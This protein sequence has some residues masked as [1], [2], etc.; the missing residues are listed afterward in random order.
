MNNRT[1]LLSL[2][3]NFIAPV[4]P[5]FAGVRNMAVKLITWSAALIA[6]SQ[7]GQIQVNPQFIHYLTEAVKI[8]A[9]VGITA[10]ATTDPSATN[11][12]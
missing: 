3:K 6:L 1:T 5:S 7:T 8:A 2:Y 4:H 10:Q 11:P 9:A 12:A